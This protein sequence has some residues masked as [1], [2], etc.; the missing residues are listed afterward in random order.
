ML[1]NRW[2]NILALISS[3]K[4]LRRRIIIRYR[5]DMMELT[6]IVMY[7]VG[8]IV[9]VWLLQKWITIYNKFVYWRTR[10]ERSFADIDVIMQ[11]RIDML[12]ALGNIAKKYD[13]HEWK[14][15]KETIEARSRWT[16]DTSLYE[17]VKN[18]QEF[19]NNLFKIQTVFEKYPKLK[20][21]GLH[22][23]MMG[24][25]NVSSVEHRLGEARLHYNRI[26]QGYNERVRRFPRMIVAWVH[27]F[28]P[29]GYLTLGNSINQE[30][31][32][33]YNPKGNFND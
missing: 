21:Y 8:A 7:V 11:Q 32:E 31:H 23:K 14:A 13:I 27:G 24:H 22:E 28:K 5:D 20:A 6:T 16:K 18:T 25:G 30:S 33:P 10:A 9:L 3:Q 4:M 1:S 17:K 15:L 26:A 2:S 19:E 29:L 12:G